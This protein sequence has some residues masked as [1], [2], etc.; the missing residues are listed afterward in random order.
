LAGRNSSPRSDI[1]P[2]QNRNNLAHLEFSTEWNRRPEI[3]SVGECK[4]N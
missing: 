3:S 4:N 2:P 1:F